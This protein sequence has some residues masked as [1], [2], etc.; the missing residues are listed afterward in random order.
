MVDR[1]K[2]STDEYVGRSCFWRGRRN[3]LKRQTPTNRSIDSVQSES[4]QNLFHLVQIEE[5]LQVI[6]G[7]L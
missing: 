7:G 2:G 3:L 4:N 6:E 5:G 1:I